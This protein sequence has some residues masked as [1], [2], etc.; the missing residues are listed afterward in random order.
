MTAAYKYAGILALG[1]LVLENGDGALIPAGDA[2]VTILDASD[3]VPTYYTDRTKGTPTTPD[4]I[5]DDTGIVGPFFVDPGAYTYTVVDSTGHT[6]PASGAYSVYVGP[7]SEEP[8]VDP[9]DYT[10]VSRTM[11]SGT[12]WQNTNPYAVI[13]RIPVTY[14]ATSGAAAELQVAIAATSPGSAGAAE[15]TQPV[16]SLV[17]QQTTRLIV[18]AAWYLRVDV[19]H[20]A[21]AAGD[22]QP[23]VA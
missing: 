8:T 2:T 16:N 20:A 5:T 19:T 13:V 14:S 15:I 22:Y 3:E 23:V 17:I 7:D 9:V 10:P 11:V 6:H 12:P 1:S 21:I 18:P 4:F